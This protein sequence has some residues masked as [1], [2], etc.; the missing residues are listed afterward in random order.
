MN[1]LLKD[2]VIRIAAPFTAAAAAGFWFATKLMAIPELQA[3]KVLNIIGISFDLVGVS[4]FSHFLSSNLRFQT[5]VVGPLAENILMAFVA[6]P[7]G[8]IICVHF[9][10]SGPSLELV[11][12]ITYGVGIYI[13]LGATFFIRNFVVASD[14]TTAGMFSPNTR[15]NILGLFFLVGGLVLQMIAAIQDLYSQ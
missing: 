4:L 11:K 7:T 10:P 1:R 15:A 5:L 12:A 3:F 2:F 8:M 9:G 13:M 6:I 14:R